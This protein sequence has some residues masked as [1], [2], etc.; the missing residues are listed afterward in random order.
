M[1]FHYIY[2]YVSSIYLFHLIEERE[3]QSMNLHFHVSLHMKER[4]KTIMVGE[5]ASGTI[6]YKQL[7]LPMECVRNSIGLYE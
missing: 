1:D 2:E 3:H 7:L 6:M 4:V 5:Y